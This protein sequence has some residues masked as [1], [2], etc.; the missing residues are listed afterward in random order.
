MTLSFEDVLAARERQQPYVRRTPT[1]R[2]DD[3][4]AITGREV[5]LKLENVQRTGAFKIRGAIARMVGLHPAELERGVVTASA[6]NHG[7]G[8]ALAARLLG[9]PATIVMPVGAP[10]YKVTAVQSHG[11]E[12]ILHGLTY[13][14]SHVHAAALASERDAAYI[15]A[16]DDEDVVAGQGVV[17]L[18]LVEQ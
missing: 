6:G 16:F 5:Y 4:S 3:L 14:D 17:G 1:E 9:V 2:S 8:V 18:E 7:Q 15:H 10:L 11:A 13:D 12:V